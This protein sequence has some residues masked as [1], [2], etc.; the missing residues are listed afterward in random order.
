M[1]FV[2]T[3]KKEALE[4]LKSSKVLSDV[5]NQAIAALFEI[6]DTP[7]FDKLVMIP[8]EHQSEYELD[9][10]ERYQND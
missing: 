10:I 4:L 5:Q 3:T 7:K 6:D 2:P 8:D 9:I 1:K